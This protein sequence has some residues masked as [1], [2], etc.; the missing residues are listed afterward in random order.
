MVTG[1]ACFTLYSNVLGSEFMICERCVR[2]CILHF[3]ALL[4]DQSQWPQWFLV[5]V[6]IVHILMSLPGPNFRVGVSHS[7]YT[8][9]TLG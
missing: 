2:K 1:R 4:L 7:A 3:V 9:E 8:D 5:V 6:I